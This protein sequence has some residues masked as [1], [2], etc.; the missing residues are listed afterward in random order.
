MDQFLSTYPQLN[1]IKDDILSEW[2][3]CRL[4]TLDG[5]EDQEEGDKLQGDACPILLFMHEQGN[6]G[7]NAGSRHL[8]DSMYTNFYMELVVAATIA[9]TSATNERNFSKLKILKNRLRSTM[10]DEQ[11]SALMQMYCERDIMDSLDSK[12]LVALF[13]GTDTAVERR[14]PL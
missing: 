1:K 2:N 14:I 12:D 9:F 3:L 7:G 5:D 10:S 4:T 13:A 11:L 6:G 8:K